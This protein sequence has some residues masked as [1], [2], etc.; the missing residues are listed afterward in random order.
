LGAQILPP[1]LYVLPERGEELVILGAGHQLP[2]AVLQTGEEFLSGQVASK[3]PH[4][5]VFYVIII[6]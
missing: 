3:L 6:S 5:P 1:Q 4:S 2:Q